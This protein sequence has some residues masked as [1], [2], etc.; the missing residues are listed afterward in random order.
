MDQALQEEL[1]HILRDMRD[2][3]ESQNCR[4]EKLES[5]AQANAKDNG[6]PSHETYENKHDQKLGD[7]EKQAE[8]VSPLS[9]TQPSQEL[10]LLSNKQEGDSSGAEQH[11]FDPESSSSPKFKPKVSSEAQGLFSNASI[12]TQSEGMSQE[13]KVEFVLPVR[14]YYTLRGPVPNYRLG[15]EFYPGDPRPPTVVPD[16]R[17]LVCDDGWKYC[18]CSRSP[19]AQL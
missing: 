1:I 5:S 8:G 16:T 17:H 10:G 14:V 2:F 9:P 13:K 11:P 19:P 6:S 4:L 7:V 15:P 3:M 18:E 12:K